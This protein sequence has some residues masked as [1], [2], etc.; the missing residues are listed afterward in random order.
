MF[1]GRIGI[2]TGETDEPLVYVT[3][4]IKFPAGRW[5][6]GANYRGVTE[7]VHVGLISVHFFSG[8]SEARAMWGFILIYL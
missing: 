8:A 1:G 7:V 3:L 6:R 5:T 4:P 2:C